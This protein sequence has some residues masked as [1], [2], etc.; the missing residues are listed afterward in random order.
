MGQVLSGDSPCPDTLA[1]LSR[2]RTLKLNSELHWAAF[3]PC[4]AL[5]RLTL[6][7]FFNDIHIEV[8]LPAHTALVSLRSDRLDV[9]VALLLQMPHLT[10]LQCLSLAMPLLTSP[11]A[12]STL[13]T[14]E[15]D[16]IVLPNLLSI[17][18]KVFHQA[19]DHTRAA[20]PIQSLAATFPNLQ[21]LALCS[22]GGKAGPHLWPSCASG[23]LLHLASITAPPYALPPT[24]TECAVAVSQI[25][26]DF[27]DIA[28]PIATL[29]KALSVLGPHLRH[30]ELLSCRQLKDSDL[31]ALLVGH[32]PGL[33]VVTFR[34]CLSI[35]DESL[36]VLTLLPRLR[37]VTVVDCMRVTPA[38]VAL[39][40]A[41]WSVEYIELCDCERVS[42]AEV[43]VLHDTMGRPQLTM[44]HSASGQRPVCVLW[45]VGG[46]RTF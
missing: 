14:A 5:T 23:R 7:S 45:E 4:S 6:N 24:F 41:C 40:A 39:L 31:K 44:V 20:L 42:E 28:Y 26:I 34:K 32:S 27:R 22:D 19:V 46:K 2:L 33:E 9:S 1:T 30:L 11:T 35:S 36:G 8:L 37:R 29:H 13:P 12:D 43:G 17:D 21:T 18:L 10:D 15:P 16:A 25:S 38:G 3:S